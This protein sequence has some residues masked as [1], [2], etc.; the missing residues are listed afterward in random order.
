VL[1]ILT[2][3]LAIAIIII[4]T[5]MAWTYHRAKL[6]RANARARDAQAA[7]HIL[8]EHIETMVGAR[9]SAIYARDFYRAA[10]NDII[11]CT[12]S[13]DPAGQIARRFINYEKMNG[14]G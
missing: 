1:I 2:I 7:A 11:I 3:L 9:D 5:R 13:T 10:L 14:E 4:V 12:D 6:N 8:A